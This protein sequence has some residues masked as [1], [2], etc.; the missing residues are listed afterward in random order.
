MKVDVVVLKALLVPSLFA[1]LESGCDYRAA[2]GLELKTSAIAP[3]NGAGF[4]RSGGPHPALR[5]RSSASATRFHLQM[6]DSCTASST[7]D[8]PSP[9]VDEPALT[10]N[11]HTPAVELPYR[12]AAPVGT[13]YYWR[14]RACADDVCGAWSATRYV[15]AGR[16]AGALNTDL[17]GDGYSDLVI[18]APESS[19]LAQQAGQVFVYLGGLD[20]RGSPALV[21]GSDKVFDEFGATVAMVGDVNG[22]GFGDFLVRTNGDEA[23]SGQAPTPRALLYFGGTTLRA[24]PDVTLRAGIVDDENGAAAGIGDV[25]GDGFDDF[26]FAGIDAGT[27][28]NALPPARVEVHLGGPNLADAADLTL[29]GQLD[30]D[31]FGSAIAGAGD[32][33]GDGF[34]DLVVGSHQGNMNPVRIYFGGPAMDD[35][36]DVTLTTPSP[37]TAL[38]G[39]S[40]AIAGD[41]NGD[42]FED[43]VVGAPGTDAHP[44]PP[45]RADVYFGGENMDATPDV[46]FSGTLEAEWFA[47]I[48]APAGDVNGD[49]FADV[50][51]VTRGVQTVFP[52]DLPGREDSER[53]VDVFFGGSA[54]DTTA[55]VTIAAGTSDPSPRGFAATDLDGDAIPDLVVGRW[56][57]NESGMGQ[58][59]IFRGSSGYAT[60]AVTL[61]GLAPRDFFGATIAR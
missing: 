23:T 47:K 24:T 34:P 29:F 27:N 57:T 30:S 55:D 25:N 19:A 22:D 17:N 49:G 39:F 41:I 60:P 11:S 26:A 52:T 2:I 28:H 61:S 51:V 13:R 5:W 15:V 45:G 36:A 40:V 46:T 50:A 12:A 14:V 4:G 3:A 48:V 33:N 20:L 7:C 6:D 1:L 37:L 31:F 53:R 44:S 9:E 54:P 21:I 10:T 8:F 32:V 58:V 38:F 18:A 56:V 42:G 43:V 35:V 16:T 59:S